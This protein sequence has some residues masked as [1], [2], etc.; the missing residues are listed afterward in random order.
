MS[1]FAGRAGVHGRDECAVPEEEIEKF[2]DSIPGK[3]LQKEFVRAARL[4]E[5]KF[6][7]SFSVYP[8]VQAEGDTGQ[9]EGDSELV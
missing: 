6:V 9:A 4:E 5:I 1:L 7:R 8:K 2:Y 3:L